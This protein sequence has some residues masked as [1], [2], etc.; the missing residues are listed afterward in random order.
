MRFVNYLDEILSTKSDVKILRTLFRYPTKEFN[1][2]ELARISGVGQKTVNRA[3]PKYVSHGILSV[4]TIGKANIYALNSRHYITEQLK[5]L[6]LAEEGAKREL[7]HL[8]RKAFYGDKAVISLAIF[9]SVARG[10]EEPIS[11]IDVFILTRD[12]K[13]AERKLRKVGEII[14]RRFGNVISGYVLT[15]RD[16]EEKRGTPTIKEIVV[17]GEL[18]VGRSLEE[19]TE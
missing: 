8:L 6:F 13:S 15:P 1:E 18:I 2:N 12:K 14:M 16:F 19:G 10:R 4:R 17:D 5:S 9:G 11:D 3:M 7:K